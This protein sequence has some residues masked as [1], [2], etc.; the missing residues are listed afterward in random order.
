[1]AKRRLSLL[2][3]AA[4]ASAA[5]PASAQDSASQK[6][7]IIADVAAPWLHSGSGIDVPPKLGNLLRD[8]IQQNGDQ[9]LDVSV[10]YRVADASTIFTLYI[11][12]AWQPTAPV[13]FSQI[14]AVMHSDSTAKRLGGPL[15]AD[16]IITAFAPPGQKGATALRSAYSVKSDHFKSTGSA[17]IPAGDWLVTV[18][19][20]STKLDK[21]ALDVALTEAVA[22]LAI[23]SP[24]REA[25]PAVLIAPC[26]A[27]MR[28]KTA[29]RVIPDMMDSLLSGIES[30]KA[31]TE[32]V[33]GTGGKPAESSR[34]IVWCRDASSTPFYGVYRDTGSSKPGYFMA[35]GDA[36]I[37]ADVQPSLA[38]LVHNTKR[39][40]VI[41]HMLDRDYSFAPFNEVPTPA[42]VLEVVQSDQP[43]G[44]TDRSGH[45]TITVTK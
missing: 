16:P 21:A 13:W 29:K 32:Q 39:I 10:G 24:K 22:T 3:P 36:G 20:S 6:G 12:R 17:V 26:P 25:D 11:F 5:S 33:N 27:A 8:T 2:V 7:L 14:D 30:S 35:L 34:P 45:T 38:G 23:P 37:A 18:R 15:E 41:L 19:M 40:A 9:Q 31:T 44:S 28:L 1:M 4:L 43:I 42:Q